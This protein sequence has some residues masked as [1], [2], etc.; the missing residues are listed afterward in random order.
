MRTSSTDTCLRKASC[1]RSVLWTLNAETAPAWGDV[2]FKS[3]SSHPIKPADWPFRVGKSPPTEDGGR[4]RP[5]PAVAEPT[6]PAFPLNQLNPPAV[7]G[8]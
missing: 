4:S 7:L 1:K 5:K 8:P 6:P 2:G 3:D